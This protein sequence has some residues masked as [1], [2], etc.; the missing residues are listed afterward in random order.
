MKLR[1]LFRLHIFSL[2]VR[3]ANTAGYLPETD[4]GVPVFDPLCCVQP[5][6]VMMRLAPLSAA[7]FP[8]A[9]VCLRSLV[10]DLLLWP[11]SH[12]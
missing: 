12:S 6:A 9:A 2:A 1:V 7:P 3:R 10:L 11:P 5:A 4:R 8:S